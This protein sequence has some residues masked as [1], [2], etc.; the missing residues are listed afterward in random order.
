MP[1]IH[2]FQYNELPEWS[3]LKKWEIHRIP[4]GHTVTI[5]TG[6]AKCGVYLMNGKITVDDGHEKVLLWRRMGQDVIQHHLFKGG[7][8]TVECSADD[9]WWNENTIAVFSGD[10]GDDEF[11]KMGGFECSNCDHPFNHGDPVDYPFF[12]TFPNHYHEFDEY[13]L[14]MRG[15]GIWMDDGKLYNVEPGDLIA[16]RRGTHHHVV[17]CWDDV[18]IC[19]E[20]GA[21]VGGKGRG[22][23]F[24]YEHTDGKPL[25]ND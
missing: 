18:M 9:N 3:V 19:S 10:W 21:R 13:F 20:F 5:E 1:C 11:A 12:T 8:I 24:L 22:G 17:A 14:I 16:T 25:C 2:N 15:R 4:V 23:A 6:H 7:K